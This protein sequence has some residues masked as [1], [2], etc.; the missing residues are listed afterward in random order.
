MIWTLAALASIRGPETAVV[1][2]TVVL[3]SDTEVAWFRR[4]VEPGSYDN[5]AHCGP[6]LPG[7]AQPLPVRWERVGRGRALELELEAGAHHFVATEARA[8]PSG[9]EPVHT[10]AVRVDDSYVGL[11]HE[12]IG[13]P[14][15]FAPAWLEDGHQTDLR[16]ATD[17][18]AL[19]IYGQRRLGRRVP[20]V[21]PHK[22]YEWLEPAEGPVRR[23]DV[24]HWGWQTAVVAEDRAPLGVL[25]AGDEL[26][27]A[28]K[29]TAERRT[30]GS[31]PF[32]GTPSARM[33][34]PEVES[35]TSTRPPRVEI[36]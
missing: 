35:P 9:D 11:L 26:I 29:G 30:L 5:A 18:V 25:D 32:A 24:L 31:L 2:Q 22:L 12:L 19:V 1:G 4:T 36:P 15:V 7:C 33:R 28:W 21:S 17:C 23:G 27:L 8:D 34:W 3:R 16:L 14:F 20:Y 10:V 6:P 13:T